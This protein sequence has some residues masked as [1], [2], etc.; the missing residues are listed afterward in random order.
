VAQFLAHPALLDMA[1]TIGLDLLVDRNE[2]LVYAP[3]SVERIRLLKPLPAELHSR[4]V[5]V[6]DAPGRM[7]SFDVVLRDAKGQLVAVLEHLA[8]RALPQS[9]LA[10]APAASDARL[11]DLLLARGIRAD[12]AP[13]VFDRALAAPGRHL[14]VS[15][16]SLDR[17]RLAIA[18][19]GPKV[20]KKDAAADGARAI[21]APTNPVEQQLADLWAELLG[22]PA[23][24]RSDDFFALGGH[25]LNAVRMLG[26]VRK[27][28]GVD[29][30]LATL[31]E[32]PTVRALAAKVAEKRPELLAAAKAEPATTSAGSNAAVA[33]HAAANRAAAT[34]RDRPRDQDLS[35]RPR[36]SARCSAPS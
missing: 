32:G 10:Q 13:A 28:L 8:M 36:H 26:R 30:P 6:A 5:V 9:L 16:V 21:E 3:I 12:E 18:D 31:F 1:A 7:V 27:Q 20:Q 25:S 17:V 11:T 29:L 23:V 19:S 34:R 2:P 35:P 22:V 33:N 15:S 14:V 24:G 4:A